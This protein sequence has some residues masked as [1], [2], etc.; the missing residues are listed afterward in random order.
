VPA[1][2]R[3]YDMMVYDGENGRVDF[4]VVSDNNKREGERYSRRCKE[5]NKSEE[6]RS[7]A[8]WLPLN[9]PL[10][11]SSLLDV[12]NKLSEVKAK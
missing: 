6:T 9:P 2:E 7:R 5:I 8:R 10:S 11:E 3:K 4:F 12:I 1:G